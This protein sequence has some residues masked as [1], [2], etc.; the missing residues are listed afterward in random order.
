MVA[1]RQQR[2]EVD[3]MGQTIIGVDLSGPGSAA[4]TSVAVFR[5]QG[6]ALVLLELVAGAND[7]AILDRIPAGAIVGLDAPLSYWPTGGSRTSD[8]SLRRVAV[9]HG[10]PA[11]TVMAPSAPR[12]AYLTLRGVAVSRMLGSERPDARLVEVHPTVAMVLRGAS[13][14]TLKAMKHEPEARR[15]LLAWLEGQGLHGVCDLDQASDHSVAACAAALAAWQ[16]RQGKPAWIHPA[17]PPLHP[18]DFAC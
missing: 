13:V 12:M 10:L 15:E 2:A 7:Q 8:Q 5:E 16:W 1:L 14:A 17:E 18:F 11:G 6:G 4:H 3:R 9:E